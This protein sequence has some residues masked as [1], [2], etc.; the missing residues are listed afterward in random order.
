MITPRRI[1]RL[2]ASSISDWLRCPLLWYGRRMAGWPRPPSAELAMGRAIHAA[3]EAYHRGGD[4]ELELLRAWREVEDTARP[5][6]AL[7]RAVDALRLYRDTNPATPLD[8]PEV[9][10]R[11]EI[12]GLE[13]PLI[14]VLDLVR[15]TELHEFKTGRGK[16]GQKRADKELQMSAYS[17]GFEE[18]TGTVPSRHVYWII[19]TV[20]PVSVCPLET[21]RSRG[22]VEEFFETARRVFREMRTAE[23][24]GRCV[25]G[26]CEY[27]EYCRDYPRRG[28]G[29]PALV[30]CPEL[31]P[32]GRVAGR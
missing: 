7:Q 1:T 4:S 9:W 8:R 2:S 25:N 12:P 11:A 23:L 28:G 5:N 15:G 27:P 21:S 32:T 17:V 26:R 16:W 31:G 20:A 14:G 22:Q 3:F 10:F 19:T 18:L 29:V 30:E 24:V 6:G 13:I